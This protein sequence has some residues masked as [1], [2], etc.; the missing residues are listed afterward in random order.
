[1]STLC[2]CGLCVSFY[3]VC[4]WVFTLCAICYIIGDSDGYAATRL[5]SVMVFLFDGNTFRVHTHS[6]THTKCTYKLY[7]F[8][9]LLLYL[10]SYTCGTGCKTFIHPLNSIRPSHTNSC[11]L[12]IRNGVRSVDRSLYSFTSSSCSCSCSS[13]VLSNSTNFLWLFFPW[14]LP[15]SLLALGLFNSTLVSRLGERTKKLSL[16]H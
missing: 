6:H 12:C 8:V 2:L 13:S 9:W 5:S 7:V 3:S 16:E 14:N 1:M 4:A 15:F 10:P 11:D